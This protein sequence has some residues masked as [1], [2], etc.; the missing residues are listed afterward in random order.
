MQ[1]SILPAVL[2]VS[3]CI[4]IRVVSEYSPDV[5]NNYTVIQGIQKYG[6]MGHTDIVKRKKERRFRLRS[7]KIKQWNLRCKRQI[8]RY[9]WRAGGYTKKRYIQ[10]PK[11][12]RVCN[13]QPV[14]LHW[15]RQILRACWHSTFWQLFRSKTTSAS[16][17]TLANGRHWLVFSPCICHFM[18]KN[19][20]QKLNVNTP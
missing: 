5:Y 2:L 10:V 3:A 17:K 15:Q 19:P 11:P 12:E 9:V 6:S 7:K 1:K 8:S 13:H 4:P 14:E 16:L 20:L 18:P